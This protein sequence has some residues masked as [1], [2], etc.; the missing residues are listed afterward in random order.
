MVFVSSVSDSTAVEN[1]LLISPNR[2]TGVA[3]ISVR[4]DG[5]GQ[6]AGALNNFDE[7]R[8]TGAFVV[9]LQD[10]R[11]SHGPGSLIM[12]STAYGTSLSEEMSEPKQ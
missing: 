10:G 9:R 2:V 7:K 6:S 8:M 1:D 11:L 4:D 5:L 12:K 3:A